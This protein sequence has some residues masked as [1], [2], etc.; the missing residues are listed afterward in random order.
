MNNRPFSSL[1]DFLKRT[2]KKV[3]MKDKIVNLIKCGAFDN[4]E[5]L[6]RREIATKYIWYVCEPKSKLTMQNAN[7]LI[8]QGLFPKELE[9]YCDVYKLTKELRKH[10]DPDK[11]WYCGDRLNIPADKFE[12]WKKIIADSKLI[13][14][15]LI[16]DSEPR[17]VIDS[18]KWDVFYETNMNPLR[19]YI[20][21]NSAELLKKMNQNLFDAE[22]NKYFSGD[23]AQWELDS[24][25]F[26]FGK[27]PLEKVIPQ[28]DVNIT[29]V[30]NIVEGAQDGMFF[31]KGK[32]IPKMKLFS[33]AGT[34]IDKNNTKGL[35]T[36]QC[37][38]GVVNVKCYKDLYALY[39]KNETEVDA[40]GNETITDESF[41]EK[42]TH[43][44]IT[45]I[46]RGATFVP[47]VYKNSGVKCIERIVLDS[48]GNF[49]EFQ[50]K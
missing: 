28:M 34:V 45:G 47:K 29:E 24:L 6:Y 14:Q 38:S 30:Q 7:M 1:T 23:E 18:G 31:I 39:A 16:I 13:A 48:E 9:Y 43:L 27:H 21:E 4:I 32:E 25:N 33:I 26:Y 3:V 2:T 41:F 10:R 42:G 8:E 22:F 20:K 17:R 37:P 35:I 44:L 46:Q 49:K 12:S 40:D 11:L 36:V 19:K 50:E 15:D 5:H